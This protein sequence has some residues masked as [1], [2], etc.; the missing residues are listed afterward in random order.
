VFSWDRVTAE[1][2]GVLEHPVAD[3]V[4]RRRHPDLAVAAEL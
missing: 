2:E 3:R 1:L 4:A